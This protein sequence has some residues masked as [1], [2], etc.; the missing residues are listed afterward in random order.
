MQD[1]PLRL[2]AR[3]EVLHRIGGHRRRRR[4]LGHELAIRATELE[5][6]VRLSIKLVPLF[7]NG[8]VVAATK[9]GEIRERGGASIGPVP[10]V[11]ALAEPNSTPREPAAAV[12]VMERPP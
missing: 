6:A 2:V 5:R 9:H 4:D 7:M 10:D 3:A 8:A 1:Q 12:A 11:M